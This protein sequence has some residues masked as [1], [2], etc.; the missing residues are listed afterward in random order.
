MDPKLDLLKRFYAGLPTDRVKLET[1][2]HGFAFLQSLLARGA[3]LDYGELTG[4]ELQHK[5]K[6]VG[7]PPALLDH[8]LT[9]HLAKRSNVCLYFGP[10]QNSLCCFNIDNNHRTGNTAP[11]AET[12]AATR[13]LEAS[14]RRAGIVPLV[15]ASGR[16]YH[17]WCR[18]DQSLPNRILHEMMIRLAARALAGLSRAGLGPQRIKFNFYPDTRSIDVVS[19]RLFGSEHVKTHRFSQVLGPDGLRDEPG[20][21]AAFADLARG[22]PTPAACVVA[23][24]RELTGVA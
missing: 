9:E 8:L 16:G 11:I 12:L 21:W 17:V 15:V 4:H 23:A 7:V 5:Y 22:A 2:E 18:L 6:L 14:L 3:S 24:H 1:S 13:D 10:E 20:S 19:L